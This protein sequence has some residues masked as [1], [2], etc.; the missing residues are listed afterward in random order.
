MA[1]DNPSR[2]SHGVATATV[3]DHRWQILVCANV[4]FWIVVLHRD[5]LRRWVAE[6][7]AISSE[8]NRR[9]VQ[10]KARWSGAAVSA[11]YVEAV[12]LALAAVRTLL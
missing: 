8:A 2:P 1:S 12:F 10:Q 11:L 9:V 7:Y 4:T 6:E 5:A 3:F